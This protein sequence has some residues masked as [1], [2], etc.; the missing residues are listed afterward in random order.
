MMPNWSIKQRFA[1][2][3]LHTLTCASAN[4]RT[5]AVVL[6]VLDLE[7]IYILS[8]FEWQNKFPG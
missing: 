1:H 3:L 8:R 4:L 7:K 6:P 2:T 5:M